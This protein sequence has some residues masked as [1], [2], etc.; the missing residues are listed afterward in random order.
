MRHKHADIMIAYANDSSLKIQCKPIGASNWRK[1][2]E[3]TFYLTY[4]YRIKPPELTVGKIYTLSKESLF[5][6]GVNHEDKHVFQI[7]DCIEEFVVYPE[8]YTLL[9][10]LK[11]E[12]DE[13]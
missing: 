4:E 13:S 5:Y 12:T 8:G 2:S 10:K 3:P 1:V 11:L 9:N 6:L 7:T